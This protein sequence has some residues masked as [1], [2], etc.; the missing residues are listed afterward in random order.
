MVLSSSK[1]AFKLK[2]VSLGFLRQV[3]LESCLTME[4]HLVCRGSQ[5]E[6]FQTS[7]FCKHEATRYSS[8]SDTSEDSFI[9]S[10]KP[11]E[12]YNREVKQFAQ[13]MFPEFFVKEAASETPG[14]RTNP[15]S[16]MTEGKNKIIDSLRSVAVNGSCELQQ[17]IKIWFIKEYGLL[18]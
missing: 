10:A 6:A 15:S 16:G 3:K 8:S 18:A 2:R 12:S 14:P 7:L 13:V 5:V 4:S 11:A 1:P 9:L 17:R